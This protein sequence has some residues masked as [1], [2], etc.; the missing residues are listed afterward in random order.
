MSKKTP[1]PARGTGRDPAAAL[2][3]QAMALHQQGRVAEAE[4][5]YR[6]ILAAQPAHFDALHYCGVAQMQ[7]GNTEA[8][9][10]LM[11]HALQI[12]ESAD[13]LSNL[14][15]GLMR[16]NRHA[17]ALAKLDR[18]LALSSRQP[19]AHTNRG[20]ALA[21]LGR[22]EE[23]A[24]AHRKAQQLQPVFPEALNNL[25]NALR[26]LGRHEEAIQAL[27]RALAQR[28][29][30]PEAF[31]NR[32]LAEAAKG[33]HAAALQSYALALKAR[34][35]YAEAHNNRG[36]ALSL[37]CRFDEALAAYDTALSLKPDYA[38]ARYNRGNTLG[39]QNLHRP[40][41]EEYAQA[42][43][44][45]PEHVDAQWN[46]GLSL[47]VLG[48]LAAG[49]AQYDWRW[50][51]KGAELP[52]QFACPAWDGHTSLAGKRIVLW[53]EQGLGDTLQFVRYASLL[54]AQGAELV[55][56]VQPALR[57]LLTRLNGVSAVQA[58]GEDVQADLHCALLQL[59]ALLGTTLASIPA[60]VPY[61][62]AD[63]A[64]LQRWQPRIAAA[65]AGRLRVALCCS[66]NAKLANDHNRSIPLAMFRPLIEALQDQA[67]FFLMQ[68]EC[69][70]Q[71]E[72]SLASLPQL[73]DLRAELG[74]FEDTA[75]A[76]SHCDVLI[77]V[78]TSVAHLAGAL[79]K[80][81][82]LLLPFAPDWRWLLERSDSP[83]YPSARLFRQ[84]RIGDWPAVIARL[85][86]ALQQWPA[87]V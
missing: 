40:A 2:F 70:A 85:G 65:A 77:S 6:Q 87:T 61:L 79:G 26:A 37:L 54:A 74:D 41:L 17:D 31:N 3:A 20:L 59:P 69:R 64:A 5:A 52:R 71:D 12:R 21:A 34:P 46:K 15:N 22:H 72:A 14:A 50:R 23:A 58:L 60:E 18:A 57:S 8:G 42:I 78:D 16:L 51:L 47:L 45:Q 4:A 10:A 80:P 84:Q 67:C 25:G 9:V 68:K 53:A 33:E 27:N 83:W 11:E 39:A 62:H 35:H 38:Q 32:G 66:G 1:T 73:I 75:A 13:A 43:A 86:P 36:N 19:A 55:L 7:L 30:Y 28:P 24:A 49:F 56:A 48:D 76:L 44:L 29:N 82:W 63:A 81:L